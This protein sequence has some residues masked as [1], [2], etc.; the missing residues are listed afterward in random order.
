MV[1]GAATATE[2]QLNGRFCEAQ[3]RPSSRLMAID[4]ADGPQPATPVI[5]ARP[6]AM[7]RLVVYLA[8]L[9]CRVIGGERHRRPVPTAILAYPQR[10][11]VRDNDQVAG[12]D[13]DCRW[14]IHERPRTENRRVELHPRLPVVAARPGT[15]GRVSQEPAWRADEAV[16]R[17]RARSHDSV[18]AGAGV[19]RVPEDSR[20]QVVASIEHPGF[21]RAGRAQLGGSL[22]RHLPTAPGVASAHDRSSARPVLSLSAAPGGCPPM[23]R[24]DEAK[25][26]DGIAAIGIR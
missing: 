21:R 7:L 6:F 18:P 11:P 14:P 16:D 2:L 17:K 26:S 23:G 22:H 4:W 9:V 19:G 13:E 15:G 5:T 25:A 1:A 10:C 12:L 20:G 24:V 8:N 3:T